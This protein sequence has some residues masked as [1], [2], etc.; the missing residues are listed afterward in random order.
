MLHDDEEEKTSQLDNSVILQTW[1]YGAYA[2]LLLFMTSI[3]MYSSSATKL[4]KY[5]EMRKLVRRT[6]RKVKRQFK[7]L[8]KGERKSRRN[9]YESNSKF[10]SDKML[11]DELN[12]S[13]SSSSSSSA[14]DSSSENVYRK[15]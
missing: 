5:S 1:I 9:K 7:R 11:L 6:S 3:L 13:D 12:E 4:I 2:Q 8:V 10:I 15:F 14:Y